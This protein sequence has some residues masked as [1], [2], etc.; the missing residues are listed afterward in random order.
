MLSPVPRV[1]GAWGLHGRGARFGAT[2]CP[3]KSAVW[4]VGRVV[5][6]L[7][8]PRISMRL[9]FYR[10]SEVAAALLE[11]SGSSSALNNPPNRPLP[12][13]P[14]DHDRRGNSSVL[15]D[16][17][18]QSSSRQLERGMSEEVRVVETLL[19]DVSFCRQSRASESPGGPRPNRSFTALGFGGNGQAEAINLSPSRGREAQISVN[20]TPTAHEVNTETPEIRKY[21]KRFNSEILCAALWGEWWGG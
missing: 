5:A 11:G 20:V 13:T 1:P 4:N 21:K 15:P 16:V 2:L 12:P 9:W 7:S 19:P 14:E 3:T 8:S 6:E 10:P 17:L 18:P